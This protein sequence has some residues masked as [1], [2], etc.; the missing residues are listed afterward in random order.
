MPPHCPY[1][2]AV[3]VEDELLLLGAEATVVELVALVRVA[4]VVDVAPALEDEPDPEPDDEPPG[5][6]TDVVSGA[7]ST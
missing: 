2:A 7:D 1:L 5:P 6:E 4:R 3:P